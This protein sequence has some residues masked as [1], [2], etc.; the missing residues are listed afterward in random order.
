M[1]FLR[2]EHVDEFGLDDPRR[3]I[4]HKDIIL[5]KPF[6]KRIYIDWYSTIKQLCEGI[7]SGKIIELGS[8]GGFLKEVFPEV[9]T[10]DILDLPENDL[11]FNALNMPFENNSISAFVMV[12]VFHHVPDSE[13]FLKE[14]QRCLK[15]GGR[16]VMSEPCTTWFSKLIFKNFHHEPF[17][18]KGDWT[19]PGSGP[20]SDANG[21]LPYIVFER[22]RK[23]FTLTFPELKIKMMKQH[24]PLRYLL[25]G[26]VSMKQ[27]VPNFS[28]KLLTSIDRFLSGLGIGLALFQ[29]IVVQKD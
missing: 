20:M 22:D 15:P 10:S 18:E 17:N 11:T 2:L 8:G 9:T 14:M 5:G 25:S 3:T 23:R 26:G 28:F 4:V 16:I 6:L 13:L 21:A 1:K 27:L 19:I 7:P 12:D 29:F 24:S